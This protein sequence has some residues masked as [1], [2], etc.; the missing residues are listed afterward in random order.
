MPALSSTYACDQA[1]ESV[2]HSASRGHG[3]QSGRPIPKH[4]VTLRL[5]VIGMAGRID[6]LHPDDLF[7]ANAVMASAAGTGPDRTASRSFKGN[8][9]AVKEDVPAAGMDREDRQ[10]AT[11]ARASQVDRPVPV[12]DPDLPVLDFVWGGQCLDKNGFQL[13][14]FPWSY[15]AHVTRALSSRNLCRNDFVPL[16]Y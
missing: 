1:D 9:L 13:H 7:A 15:P 16:T 2:A 6:C 11:A 3:Q 10:G 4:P 14:G 8:G 12:A 5:R